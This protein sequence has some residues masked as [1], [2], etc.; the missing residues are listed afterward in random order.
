MKRPWRPLSSNFT[1]PVTSAK[2]VSS[3]PWPT[4]SPAW[5]FVPR[6]RTRIVPALTSWPPKRFT[7]SLC[8]CESRP[9][10]EEPP[11]FL[12]AMTFI[13]GNNLGGNNRYGR[14][15][16]TFGFRKPA[17][18]RRTGKSACGS[19]RLDVADLDGGVVLPVAALNLVLIGFLEL[20][21][22]EL[23]GAPL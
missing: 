17:Q 2:S 22:G 16:Q 21:N 5:C 9:F 23:L 8:P 14:P 6:W 19:L 20:Q 13:L 3:L 1:T 11:P 7:P 18:Q 12:C 10:V 15:A 4:F